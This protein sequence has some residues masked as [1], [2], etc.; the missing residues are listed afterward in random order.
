VDI[1]GAAAGSCHCEASQ[2]ENK[3]SQQHWKENDHQG[4]FVR[5]NAVSLNICV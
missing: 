3:S 5:K 4:E 1:G 2:E